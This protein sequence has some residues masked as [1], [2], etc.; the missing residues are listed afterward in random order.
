VG[1]NL[2]HTPGVA[3]RAFGALQGINI[4]MISQGASVLNI[5]FVVAACDAETTVKLLHREFFH[6]VDPAVFD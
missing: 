2:R 5:G 6:N 1:D 3:A 4:R